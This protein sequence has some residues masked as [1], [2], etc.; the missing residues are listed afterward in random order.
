MLFLFLKSLTFLGSLILVAECSLNYHA[1]F[2]FAPHDKELKVE[3]LEQ[4]QKWWQTASFYQIYPRSFK[5]SDGDG[6][7]DLN[8][9]L[10][11][12]FLN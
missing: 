1:A 8:G 7:G 11:K 5:D 2:E 6:V 10:Q 3:Y 12:Y 9:E 4:K